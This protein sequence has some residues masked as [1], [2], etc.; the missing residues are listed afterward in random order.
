MSATLAGITLGIHLL[1]L[2]SAP[3]YE[4]QNLGLYGRHTASGITAGLYRNSEGRA[5]VYLGETFETPDRRFA[6]T[7]GAVTGYRA[8]AVAPLVVP[9][10]RLGFDGSAVRLSLIPKP[11]G[12]NA[13]GLHL[14]IER[15]F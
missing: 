14:S 15:E 13:W 8:R 5:S 10:F 7:V 11:P 12:A 3:G 6:L 9:S 1:T 4:S 2:H